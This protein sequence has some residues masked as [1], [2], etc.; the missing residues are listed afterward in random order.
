MTHYIKDGVCYIQVNGLKEG[1]FDLIVKAKGERL[2]TNE[3]KEYSVKTVAKVIDSDKKSASEVF[4]WVVLCVY[5][6]GF[7]I[8]L[9]ISLVK[10]RQVSVK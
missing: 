2:G 7:A 5:G 6:G 1:E 3:V 4:L 10:A 9:I 8:F